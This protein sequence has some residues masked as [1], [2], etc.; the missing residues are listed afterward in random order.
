MVLQGHVESVSLFLSIDGWH[1][2]LKCLWVHNMVTAYGMYK[3]GRVR[4]N[5]LLEIGTNLSKNKKA[6]F[7]E[8]VKNMN[9]A[10]PGRAYD[11]PD[12][13]SETSPRS[14]IG[15]KK[16]HGMP[17]VV[18]QQETISC[19][20]FGVDWSRELMPLSNRA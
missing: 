12:R 9:T 2:Y 17:W 3:M 16:A 13:G 18:H 1:C 11:T 5:S 7:H 10:N 15:P 14:G 4:Y 8:N 20:E 6:T 19:L